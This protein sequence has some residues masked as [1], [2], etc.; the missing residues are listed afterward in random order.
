MSKTSEIDYSKIAKH[1]QCSKEQVA[2]V[3]VL[4]DEGNT[5]PFITRY[6]KER[7]GNLDENAIRLIQSDLLAARQLAERTQ[8]ILRVIET[9]GKLTPALVK[10]IENAGS[11]KMLE[12]L[13]LPYKPKRRTRATIA[14]EQGLEPFAKLIWND[15]ST[16]TSLEAYAEKYLD[17]EKDL[18]DAEAVLKGVSDII[19]EQISEVAEVRQQMRM[20]AKHTGKL[21]VKPTKKGKEEGQEF[22]DYFEYSEAISKIPPHRVMALNRGEKSTHLRIKFE[23][24]AD[25]A[26]RETV[27]LLNINQRPAPFINFWKETSTDAI[28]RL[29]LPSLERELRRE[30]TEKAEKHAVDV[31]ATNLRSLLLQPPLQGKKVLAIDPG[32]RSGCKVALLDET[33]HCLLHDVVYATGSEEKKGAAGK[34]LADILNEH[35]CSIVAIG[36]GTACRET[37]EIVAEMIT[38]HLP[39]ARYLIVNEAGASIYSASPIAGEEF[40]D[41][42]ATVRG[43]ISI[44]RRLQD[45]LSELVKID[46]QHIGVGMYQHDVNAKHLKESLDQ[47]VESCVNFVGVN[48]NTASVALLRHVS[49]LNQLIARRIVE[50]RDTNGRFTNR[51]QLHDVAGIGEATFTQAVGFLKIKNGDEPFDGTWIHPESYKTAHCLLERLSLTPDQL[52]AHQ[53]EPQQLQKK[54]SE[55]NIDKIAQ[56][57]KIGRPTLEDILEAIIKPGRDP[58]G[59]LSGPVF[60]Q[61][62]LKLN[63]LA[64]GMELTGTVLN[65]VDFGL[66]VDIGLKDS[67]LVHIS[68]MADKFI[69]NPHDLVSVGDVVTVWVIEVDSER[70]RVSLTMLDPAKTPV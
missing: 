58:R 52:T 60:K 40:P 62:V 2:Q 69:S 43:T 44:G 22:R 45:P 59:D 34:K 9:Q 33:G 48:L 38:E 30:L 37:E 8:T 1:A 28:S 20:I 11:L 65:V 51:Q 10:A 64:V 29:V 63:D 68:R 46:P 61:G 31:F 6:R 24:D 12:D 15:D 39:D 42:D 66:F 19:A 50:W 47:V 23:W 13:Y 67:G 3:V 41:L 32:F 36:N 26:N 55:L 49:G 18:P 17:T 5:V 25:W 54:I 16:I 70:K 56:E 7:T 21:I 27:K 14:R 4:L 53:S 35:H 57:S